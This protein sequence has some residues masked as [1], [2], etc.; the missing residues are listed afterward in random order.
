MR[1]TSGVEMCCAWGEQ[2]AGPASNSHGQH[3]GSRLQS[4]GIAMHPHSN[5]NRT[6]SPVVV[7]NTHGKVAVNGNGSSDSGSN[8]PDIKDGPGELPDADMEQ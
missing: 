3:S 1:K 8:S 2:V 6:A 4:H 7:S 5:S